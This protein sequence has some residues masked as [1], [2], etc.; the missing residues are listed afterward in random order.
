MIDEIPDEIWI[1]VTRRQHGY[2]Y[3]ICVTE[4]SAEQERLTLRDVYTDVS[5]HHYREG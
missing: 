1:V 4:E 5:I 3:M 2:E